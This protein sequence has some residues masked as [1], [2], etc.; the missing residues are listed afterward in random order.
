MASRFILSA[1]SQSPFTHAGL[2]HKIEGEPYVIHVIADEPPGSEDVV[3]VEP[4]EIFL[5][6]DRASLA[7]VYRLREDRDHYAARAVEL[8]LSYVNERLLFDADFDLRT[9]DKLYCTELVWRAYL[10]VGIDLVNGEFDTLSLPFNK[11][12]YLLPS[13]LLQSPWLQQVVELN[14][15]EGG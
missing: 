9:T 5:G 11:G 10:G 6:R 8:A 3:R 4:L 14:F 7:A 12:T 13:R 15:S 2:I 1:D